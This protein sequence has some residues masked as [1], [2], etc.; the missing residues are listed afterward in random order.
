MISSSFR[1]DW[2]SD[3]FGKISLEQRDVQVQ[4]RYTAMGGGSL[5]GRAHGNH[6]DFIWQ[7]VQ[8]EYGWGTIRMISGG[9]TLTGFWGYNEDKEQMHLFLAEF[10]TAELP[11]VV[12]EDGQLTEDAME[13]KYQGYN[14]FLRGHYREAVPLLEQALQLY[15]ARLQQSPADNILRDSYLIDIVNITTRLLRCH[16]MLTDYQYVAETPDTRKQQQVHYQQLLA[17][18]HIAM[19]ARRE[20]LRREVQQHIERSL[21]TFSNVTSWLQDWVEQ[22]AQYQL[23]PPD[24]RFARL[25]ALKLQLGLIYEKLTAASQRIA[26]YQQRQYGLPESVLRVLSEL[27][28]LLAQLSITMT[29]DL[30]LL[31]T[32]TAR[33]P[34][35]QRALM[36]QLMGLLSTIPLE[37][38]GQER[39]ARQAQQGAQEIVG[40]NWE[41]IMGL[42]QRLEEWRLRLWQDLDRI[43]AQEQGQPF[44]SELIRLF[45]EF[46]N[47]TE[48]LVISERAR[49][50]AYLDLLALQGS[51]P[52]SAAELVP[53]VTLT[54]I[55][56]I[57]SARDS[58]TLEYFIMEQYLLIWIILPTGQVSMV[59]FPIEKNHL[60]EM[61]GTC[62]ALIEQDMLER[63]QRTELSEILQKLY[64]VLIAPVPC[65]LL[66]K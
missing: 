46:E 61:V 38:E 1:G 52:A 45:V 8:Q 16:F 27:A 7:N 43:D 32:L 44:F 63:T 39:M 15:R 22:L 5:Q 4:G 59:T 66:P 50:R 56:E 60:E 23:S 57:V 20:L 62:L 9:R 24:P 14:L 40:A 49:A 11:P 2:I 30:A 54:D 6:L 51:V 12:S 19:H 33:W 25:Q 53:P 58:V 64:T 28:D 26:T 17:H 29:S 21:V 48:A 10:L 42:S 34:D 65:G 36:E 18:I 35:D 31:R 3:M 37:L 41:A 47:T 55:H 13:I